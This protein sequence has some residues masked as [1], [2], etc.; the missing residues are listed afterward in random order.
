MTRNPGALRLITG[1]TRS[2]YR[3]SVIDLQLLIEKEALLA[4]RAQAGMVKRDRHER[5]LHRPFRTQR[6]NQPLT[7]AVGETEKMWGKGAS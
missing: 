2:S 7:T 1:R 4:I 3:R 6:I 5:G